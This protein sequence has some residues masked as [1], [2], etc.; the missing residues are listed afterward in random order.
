MSLPPITIPLLDPAGPIDP[1]NDLLLIRQGLNDRKITAGNLNNPIL[2]NLQ[3]LPGQL[4]SSDVLLIGR[5]NGAGY[6]NYIMPPQ[7][8]GFLNGTNC[9]F[10]QATAPLG[11]TV[12]PNTGDKILACSVPG[13]TLYNGAAAGTQAGTW[14]QTEHVLTIAQ[15]PSHNHNIQIRQNNN[16]GNFVAMASNT[17]VGV[18]STEFQ[19]G[20][21]GHHHGQTWRPLA[22]IGIL[23]SKTLLVGQ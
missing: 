15:I 9:Y 6:D 10:Y 3:M 8:L 1:N 22:N 4:I 14:Q 13:G 7:Y 12:I 21:L 20:G 5:N 19:G 17:G 2:G 11:W 23:C 18:G 16:L